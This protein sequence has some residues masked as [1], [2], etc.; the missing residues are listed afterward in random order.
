MKELRI[1]LVAYG[2]TPELVMVKVPNERGRWMLTHWCVV[3]IACRL[4]G[5]VVGEPCHNGKGGALLRYSVG[6]HAWRRTDAAEKFGWAG[7][8]RQQPHKLRL[9]EEDISLPHTDPEVH[10]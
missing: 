3:M 2:V 10:S 4:C 7:H 1:G 9:N 8:R 5:A 6:T